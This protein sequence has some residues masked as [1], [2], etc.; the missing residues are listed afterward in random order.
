MLKNL[1]SGNYR[2]ILLFKRILI[3]VKVFSSG[4]GYTVAFFFHYFR[5]R[6]GYSQVQYAF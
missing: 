3:V 4:I 2:I 6:V 1:K 5:K